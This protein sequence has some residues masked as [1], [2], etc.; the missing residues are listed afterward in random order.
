MNLFHLHIYIIYIY[1]YIIFFPH[2]QCSRGIGHEL[3]SRSNTEVV[4]SNPTLGMDVFVCVY[5]VCVVL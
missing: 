2:S 1:I 3:Y 4:D 5:S